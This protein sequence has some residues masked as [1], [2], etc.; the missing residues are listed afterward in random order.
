MQTIKINRPMATSFGRTAAVAVMLLA[1]L[2]TARGAQQPTCIDVDHRALVSQSDLIYRSPAAQPSEGLPIGN[3]RMGTLV[4]TDPSAIRLQ[5][6]R[7]DVSAVN[8]DHAGLQGIP[9]PGRPYSPTDYGGA[10]AQIAIDVGGRPFAPGKTFTQRLGLYEAQA[11]ITGD[12]VG[13]RCFVSAARDVLAL[14]IDDC[15]DTPQPIRVTLSMWRP[16]EVVHGNHTARYEFAQSA[17]ATLVVQRF[18]E[19]DYHCASAVAV[20]IVGAATQAQAPSDTARLI[21]APASKG[22]RTVL[23]SSAASSAADADVG[24]TAVRLLDD[25]AQRTYDDLLAEHARW[26]RDFWSRTFVHLTSDDGIARF[27]Q[28][29]RYLHLYYMAS[30]SRGALPPRANGSIFL[31][32]GDTRRWGS[33]FW[34]WMTEMLYFPL[35][36]ADAVDLTAPFFDMYVRQLPSCEQAARQRW[37]AQG[38]AYFPETN[39]FDGPV[40]LPEDVV[41]EIRQLLSGQKTYAEVS[42]RAKALCQFD[43]HLSSLGPI[44]DRRTRQYTFISHILSSGSELAVHAWWRYRHTGDR[45]WLRTHAYPLLR[46]TVEFYRHMVQKD[47]RGRYHLSGTNAHEDFWGVKDSIMDLAAIRGTAPLAIRAAEILDVDAELRTQ[48]KELLDNLAPYPMGS[49]PQSKAL[50]GSVLA[51]DVWAAGHVG[52]VNEGHHNPEDVWLNPVFP[53]EDWT[54][55]TRQPPVDTIVQKTLDLAPKH[56]SILAGDPVGSAIRTPIAAV[57]AGRGRELPTILAGYYAALAGSYSAPLPNGMSTFEGCNAQSIEHLGL[58]S[59]ILQEALLQ[60]VSARP[61]GP[62]I[63]R[64]FPAWPKQWEA[65]FRLLARGGFLVTSAM[66]G[67][68]VECVEIESRLGESCRLRNPW[69]APCQVIEIGGKTRILEGDLLCFDTQRGKTYRL[70]PNAAEVPACRRIAPR[71]VDEPTSYSLKL[72]NGK[73]VAGR[74]GRP[75]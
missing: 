39:P 23:I 4:W 38:G 61:G 59:M 44:A 49:D 75:K 69:A 52:D 65:S 28:Q 74:L 34:V 36:A 29:V 7:V 63:M 19:K 17:D 33:Q 11:A 71:Q 13:I 42:D 60:T 57:R 73:V 48:W 55:E 43:G 8:K 40:V 46:G 72:P 41:P 30:T 15:R 18:H 20:R 32:E 70:V 12:G 24:K 5:I 64:V 67:G 37:N 9:M 47:Q 2:G 31:T 54:L 25:A 53:F 26:W 51:D 22:K 16:P 62:E 68:K 27:M 56:G 10:C 35:L 21:T 14:E 1:L 66:R 6:N 58:V 3:G 45:Q 50:A